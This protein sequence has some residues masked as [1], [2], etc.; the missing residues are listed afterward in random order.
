M[1][2]TLGDELSGGEDLSTGRKNGS[3]FHDVSA[4]GGETG[5][6]GAGGGAG[7]WSGAAGRAEL[8]KICVKLPSADAEPEAPGEE[9]PLAGEELGEGGP[10]RGVSAEGREGGVYAGETPGTKMRVNSPGA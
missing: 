7:D 2:V 3:F 10:G 1:L 9:N 5:R 4:A 8:P 6:A